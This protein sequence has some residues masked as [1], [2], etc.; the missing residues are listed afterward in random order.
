VARRG[1]CRLDGLPNRPT[2]TLGCVTRNSPKTAK[3]ALAA[4]ALATRTGVRRK[5][6]RRFI[7]DAVTSSRELAWG[8]RWPNGQSKRSVINDAV[9]PKRFVHTLPREGKMKDIGVTVVATMRC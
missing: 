1:H 3:V 7:S 9:T 2:G 8:E 5:K 4:S 6:T